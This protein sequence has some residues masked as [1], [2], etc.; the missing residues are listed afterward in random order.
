MIE[1]MWTCCDDAVY[2]DPGLLTHLAMVHGLTSSIRA[3]AK[4]VQVLDVTGGSLR[5][6]EVRIGALLLYQSVKTTN[7]GAIQI[8]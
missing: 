6:Y 7:D 2:D 5:T 1:T 8:D 3:I 4:L